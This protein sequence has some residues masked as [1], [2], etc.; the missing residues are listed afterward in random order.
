MYS[1][2]KQGV[3]HLSLLPGSPKCP[4]SLQEA[5]EG[6]LSEYITSLFTLLIS[7]TKKN[8]AKEVVEH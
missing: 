8:S 3:R 1:A 5:D 2:F 7:D 6:E 4:T